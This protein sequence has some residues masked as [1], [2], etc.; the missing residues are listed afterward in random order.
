MFEVIS[1]PMLIK[2]GFDFQKEYPFESSLILIALISL[3][4]KLIS[5]T[6]L[7]SKNILYKQNWIYIGL[8]LMLISFLIVCYGAW[9]Y[10]NILFAITFG[11]GIPFLMYFGRVLYLINQEKNKSELV[12]E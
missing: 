1:V 2:N 9:A 3:I 5:I 12:K 10:D 8:T 11:S 4:G 7:F 6:T